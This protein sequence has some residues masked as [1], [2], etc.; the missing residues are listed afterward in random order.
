MQARGYLKRSSI[1]ENPRFKL[2]P[3][4]TSTFLFKNLCPCLFDFDLLS[5][6]HES[7]GVSLSRWQSS[8]N[9]MVMMTCVTP[10]SALRSLP[11]CLCPEFIPPSWLPA[12]SPPESHTD[13]LVSHF[14]PSLTGLPHHCEGLIV[15]WLFPVHFVRVWGAC[16]SWWTETGHNGF[17]KNHRDCWHW[18][19]WLV[20]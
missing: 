10:R 14:S 12:F 7:S 19:E 17:I 6:H 8:S 13:Y 3:V 2:S 16:Q 5:Y 18:E 20:R 1:W 9:M 11:G 4:T 15:L